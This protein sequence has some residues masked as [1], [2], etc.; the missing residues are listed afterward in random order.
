MSDNRKNLIIISIDNLRADAIGGF[1]LE[2]NWQKYN[3]TV[4]VNTPNLS[5]IARAGIFFNNCWSSAPYTTNAH[6]SLLTGSW[7]YQHGVID[8]F[9]APLHKPT[10]LEILKMHGY[11]TL[12]QTDFDFL[13]GEKLGFIRG[14]DKFVAGQEKESLAWLKN[15]NNNFAAFFHFADVHEPYGLGNWSLSGKNF[16]EYVSDLLDK[17]EI[18]PLNSVKRSAYYPLSKKVSDEE[19]LV[20]QNYRQVLNFLYEKKDYQ[21][22]MELY[23]GGL[24]RFDIGRFQKF[25]QNLFDLGFLKNTLV[26]IVGDHGEVFDADNFGHNKSC[27]KGALS[28]ELLRVPLLF[29]SNDLG[30]ASIDAPVRSIDMVP[31]VMNFLGFSDYKFS[32]VDLFSYDKL[33]VDLPCFGQYWSADSALVTIFMNENLNSENIIQPNFSSYLAAA[34][35]RQSSFGLFDYYPKDLKAQTYLT[36]NEEIVKVLSS[37]E[38]ELSA[39]RRAL[40]DY[41]FKTQVAYDKIEKTINSVD[42][43]ELA[44]QLRA[45]G[46][47]V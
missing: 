9:S 45:I 42:R 10:I 47:K 38:A 34:A 43:D 14:V 35:L 3:L 19:I 23:L 22:I 12:W 36:K 5:Q 11:N 1:G 2:K 40:D 18:T 21:A 17:Y 41:N 25:W 27:G 20:R 24:K 46:Y 8:F 26:V 44:E 7:P 28:E 37:N 32:G 6:A 4:Q 13:L 15:K 39:L 29:W 33:S 16:S 30:Q 31:T